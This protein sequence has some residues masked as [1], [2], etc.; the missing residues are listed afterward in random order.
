MNLRRIVYYTSGK[1]GTG[2]IIQGGAVRNGLMRKGLDVEFILLC[3]KDLLWV[4][5]LLN[6]E[7]IEV[8]G[9]DEN[10]LSETAY[11]SSVLYNTLIDINPDVLIVKHSWYTLHHFINELK[12]KK[13][14]LAAQLEDRLFHIQLSDRELHINPKHYDAVFQVEPFYFSVPSRKLNPIIIRNKDEIMAREEALRALEL[15]GDRP[16]CFLG[17]NGIRGEF[18]EMKKTY[19]YLEDEGYEMVY[20]TN[21][22]GGLFPAVD[23][24]N[25]FD[26]LICGAGYNAF[27]EAIYFK[28]EAIFIP[29]PRPFES[30]R[31]RVENCQDYE[32]NKNGADQLAEYIAML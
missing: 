23:Y 20:S 27:W 32:F 18:E 30:Q 28:K 16:V 5:N 25:A 29:V 17:T 14:F 22:Q 15:T 31:Q 9:E 21:Y 7:C 24:F 12:T 2:H 19:S 26:L 10:Q 8:P 11:K 4:G 1:T 13:I 6:I 3:N